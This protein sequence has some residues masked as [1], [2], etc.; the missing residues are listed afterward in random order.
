MANGIT[1]AAMGNFTRGT[2]PSSANS[3]R[4][5]VYFDTLQASAL[6]RWLA[7]TARYRIYRDFIRWMKPEPGDV[8]L[9]VGVSD[10]ITDEANFLESHYPYRRDIVC[11]G[12]GDGTAVIAAYPGVSYRKIEPAQPLPFADG[13]FAVAT[14][15]A[16]LEHVG[17]DDGKRFLVAEMLRVARRIFVAVPNRWFP[18]EPHT[19][20]PLLHYWPEAFRSYCARGKLAHWA[21]LEN[22]DFIAAADFGRLMPQDR[23]PVVRYSGLRLGPLSSNII[24]VAGD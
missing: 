9:D 4:D 3:A 15:N 20:L 11:A 22:L 16:V 24:C 18:V 23:P 8:I 21:K 19:A 14:C 1:L 17:D 7:R 5:E 10:V 2:L 12:L 6:A 13:Q